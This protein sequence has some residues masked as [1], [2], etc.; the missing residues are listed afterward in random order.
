[1]TAGRIGQRCKNQHVAF[2]PPFFEG[3]GHRHMSIKGDPDVG[4]KNGRDSAG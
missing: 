1:L 4:S 2:A 3:A